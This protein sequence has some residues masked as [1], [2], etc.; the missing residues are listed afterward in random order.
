LA[1]S[2]VLR[3][4]IR[5][6][7]KGEGENDSQELHVCRSRIDEEAVSKQI[8]LLPSREDDIAVDWMGG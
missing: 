4:L 6:N 3:R 2:V 1:A 8:K 7:G 5:E